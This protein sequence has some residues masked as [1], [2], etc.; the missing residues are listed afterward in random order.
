MLLKVRSQSLALSVGD[1]RL[2]P[3]TEDTLLYAR[4]SGNNRV[5]VVLNFDRDEKRVELP[6]TRSTYSIV[7][8]T[9]LDRAGTIAG[10]ELV[11]RPNEG[12]IIS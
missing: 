7:L 3:S 12:M 2:L 1:F 8:S 5:L 4:S 9:A 6:R 10:T 11:L